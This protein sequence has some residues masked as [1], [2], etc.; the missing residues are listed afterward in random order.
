MTVE[1][2]AVRQEVR[3]ILNEA[4]INRNTMKD[5]VNQVIAEELNKA[6]RQ[7]M[8]EMDLDTLIRT[9]TN[10]S[11]QDAVRKELR[12]SIDKRVNGV[13]NSMR[14]SVDIRNIKGDSSLSSD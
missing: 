4:G 9:K 10:G 6:V 7:V 3:Q 14:I 1:Q 2:I 11:L 8:Y 12:E 5:I 13:F